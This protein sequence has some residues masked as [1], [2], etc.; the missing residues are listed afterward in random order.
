MPWTKVAVDHGVESLLGEG[1]VSQQRSLTYA[2]A[3]REAQDQA[4]KRDPRV[5]LL[6]EGIDDP[7][8]IFGSTVGLSED[9][10]GRVF[11][12]PIAENALTG[13]TT[14][15]ALAGMRPIF[16]HMRMDF[17][18]LTFDQILNHA[19]KIRYM[20][21]GKVGVPWVIRSVIGKGWGSAAQHSQALHAFFM[22]MPGLKVLM[23]STPYD[24]KGLLLSSIADPDPVVFIEHRWLYDIKG[25]VPQE[26]YLIP[27][28]KGLIRRKGSDVT[29]LA[30]SLMVVEALKAA[31]SLKE[32]GI[33][34]EI[35][36]P[37]CLNPLDEELIM[38]SV[39]KTGRLL[40]ADLGWETGGLAQ[41]LG[42]RF[43]NRLR[44]VLKSDV[45]VVALPDAPTPAS[46]ELEKYFYRDYTHID[47]AVR[48]ML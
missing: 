27:L 43:F 39:C 5:F 38:G 41:M 33:E 19:A 8:G 1:D 31:Q 14:G 9:F 28:G 7:G 45:V 37:R 11:D 4:L 26:E 20:S 10:K 16:I 17:M 12:T 15:A 13:I 35:V 32:S 23:P 18:P 3:L 47:R 46:Q 24:A 29:V 44:K 30:T 25:P 6:G 21:G 22:H 2:Q 42:G 34:I 40:I 36:D 48:S